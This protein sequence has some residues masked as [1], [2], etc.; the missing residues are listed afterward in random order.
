MSLSGKVALVTGATGALGRVVT[1]ILLR[2][3]ARVVSTYK[4]GEM[5]SELVDYVRELAK[6][7]TDVQADVTNEDSVQA[8]FWRAIEENGRVDILLN[9]IGTYRGATT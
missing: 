3:G 2:Q 5:Q 9:L 6:T 4:S 1:K 7:L 8:L